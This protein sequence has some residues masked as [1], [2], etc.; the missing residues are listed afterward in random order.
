MSQLDP[1]SYTQP[2]EYV[3]KP[4]NEEESK[5][6]ADSIKSRLET[7]GVFVEIEELMQRFITLEV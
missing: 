4:M 1:Y 7:S 5:K 6:L 2:D 3:V